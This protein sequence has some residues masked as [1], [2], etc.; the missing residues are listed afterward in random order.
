MT[1][2]GI[3]TYPLEEFKESWIFSFSGRIR[4]DPFF[5]ERSEDKILRPS[6][7]GLAALAMTGGGSGGIDNGAA[8]ALTFI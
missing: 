4:P 7:E 8:S 6:V 5:F 1:R 2:C 3:E